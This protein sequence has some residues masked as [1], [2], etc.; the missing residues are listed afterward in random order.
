M[1]AAAAGSRPYLRAILVPDPAL[2]PITSPRPSA[3]GGHRAVVPGPQDSGEHG[4]R[5]VWV[6]RRVHGL[7]PAAGFPLWLQPW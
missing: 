6:H 1:A 2:L 5:A 3:C 7:R 4:L